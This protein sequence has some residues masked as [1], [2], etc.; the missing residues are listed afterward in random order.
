MA[1]AG[2]FT[3]F[4]AALVEGPVDLVKSKM[5]VQLHDAPQH[6]TR[7]YS[8][9]FDCAARLWRTRGARGLYQGLDATLARNVPGSAVYFTCYELLRRV[10]ASDA[11]EMRDTPSVL[12]AGGLSGMAFWIS[13]YPMDAI[14]SRMQ[15]DHPD[16]SA[17]RY[18]SVIDCAR[19]VWSA[20]GFRGFWRGFAPC[21]LRAFPVNAA[22]F[23]AF[24]TTKSYLGSFFNLGNAME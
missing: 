20:E 7:P 22:S 13:C 10:L 18:R 14:K 6:H 23:L 1:C 12:V 4:C 15:T 3:G 17:R 16:P 11:G 5:Q 24:E 8:S 2:L 9:S 21:L 19:Q